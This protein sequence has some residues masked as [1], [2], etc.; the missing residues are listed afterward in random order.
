[1]AVFNLRLLSP[2]KDFF[3]GEVTE[4]IFSLADG[5]IGIMA[6][7]AP[8]VAAVTEGIMEILID[9]EW[10]IAAVSQGFAEISGER[11][12]FYLDTVEWADEIDVLRAKEALNR[13]ESRSRGNLNYVEQVRTQAAMSRALTRLKAA[14]LNSNKNM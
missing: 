4:V 2:E 14:S 7:H 12:E 1:M 13:A 9:G 3:E 10:K 11:A 8:S 5:R 6:G